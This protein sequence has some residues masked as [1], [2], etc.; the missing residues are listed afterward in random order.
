MDPSLSDVLVGLVTNVVS[1]ILVRG[2]RRTEDLMVGKRT[3]EKWRHDKTA[4]QPI[5]DRAVRNVA[6]AMEWE[7]P[8][9]LEVASLFL[10][11]PESHIIAQQIFAAKLLSTPADRREQNHM[12]SIREEFGLSFS[13]FA[14]GY[15]DPRGAPSN[16]SSS[17]LFDLL[18][19][20]CEAALN[21]AIDEGLLAAHD[22][23]SNIRLQI[24]RDD[25]AGLKEN[26][27]FLA[28]R[29]KPKF[30]EIVQFE[31]SYRKQVA[32]R[33]GFITPPNFD[34]TRKL[35]IENLYVPPHLTALTKGRST[36]TYTLD[37]SS[38]VSRLYRAI[39]LGN[40][41]GG[42]STLTLK[43]CSDLSAH[44]EAVPFGGRQVTPI[45]VVLRD[46][47]AAKKEKSCS[48][49]DYIKMT[50]NSDY[51]VCPPNGFF[52]YLLL[53]GRAL[54]IFDGLDEL[55]D[56]SYRQK[57]GSD[58]ES[59]CTRYPSVPVI[60]TSREVGYDQAPLDTRKFDLFRLAP[61]DDDQMK[62]YVSKWFALE[63]DLSPQQC[64][65]KVT[66]FVDESDAVA[67]LRSNPL[68]L[69]LMC[70]IYRG[71][72]Y[73]PRNRPDVY[74]KC[75]TMLFDRWDKSRNIHTNLSIE[76]H[77]RPTLQYLA[78]WIYANEGL[79]SG[80]TES[81]LI[82]KA[83]E[84]LC[85]WRF[86]DQFEA[87]SAAQEF[88]EYCRGRA[89]V[90]T[91]TGTTR[92]G[93]SL[94]Q[95]T[96]STF[97]EYFTATY[98]VRTNRTP[99]DLLDVL[100]PR[101]EKREWDVVAQLALQVQNK[102]IEGAGDEL[103]SALLIRAPQRDQQIGRNLIAFAARCLEFIVPRPQLTR[104][105]TAACCAQAL[106]IAINGYRSI[107]RDNLRGEEALAEL[108]HALVSSADENR[109]KIAETVK[110]YV[111]EQ[112]E[113]ESTDRAALAL[114]LGTNLPWCAYDPYSRRFRRESAE[115]WECV[116]KEISEELVETLRSFYSTNFPL[117][118]NAVLRGKVSFADVVSWY[119]PAG[120]FKPATF[121]MFPWHSFTT[122]S[123]QLFSGLIRMQAHVQPG[124]APSKL[125][126]RQLEEVGDVLL[127]CPT[128]W[129]RTRSEQYYLRELVWMYERRLQIDHGSDSRPH[130]RQ[131]RV[132]KWNL[133]SSA[134]FGA[135]VLVAPTFEVMVRENKTLD[136]SQMSLIA[137]E[138]YPLQTF[139][140]LYSLLTT[141]LHPSAAPDLETHLAKYAFTDQQQDFI[142]RWIRGESNLVQ[143]PRQRASLEQR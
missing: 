14:S 48:I 18:L 4:L 76:A 87:E 71:E 133:D 32:A 68:M 73:I 34:A 80:V 132:K 17:I 103:L 16:R 111:R 83:T 26:L 67:D 107:A 129:L 90:F 141:R 98:L 91:D 125:V 39:I 64:Q 63:T 23:K 123:Q 30:D 37:L 119:G 89:W 100:L 19:E 43:L 116:A 137:P 59:F 135:F 52:E 131:G 70:N 85:Q 35:P 105:V 8:P 120:I 93:E 140:P 101:I 40:P 33:H 99:N 114:E 41:G 128:P 44:H 36:P 104:D 82:A 109:S 65:E 20:G 38:F 57:I 106:Q 118:L 136:V 22:A 86:D 46:Y 124:T 53:N 5:L 117:C 81:R 11:S 6:D 13:L 27:K 69:A 84:Y 130:S 45:L 31:D 2:L 112:V 94:Y 77:L 138:M 54:V 25:I 15:P 61:F 56:T 97:L 96:H 47:G 62:T 110:E 143:M 102:N 49:L 92:E 134:L 7:G 113:L 66:A 78:H 10:T 122:L 139:D 55:L 60:V 51:Q 3:L 24:L 88:I 1:S 126:L 95:F 58:V 9:R 12:A 28:D 74:E 121:K 127:S 42:K 142:L 21:A 72:N 29:T 108:L 79:R 50:A 75:A 115:Y